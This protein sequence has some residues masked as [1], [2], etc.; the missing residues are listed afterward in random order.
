[1]EVE[2][3]EAIASLSA[4]LGTIPPEFIMPEHEQP[5]NSTCP[6]SVFEIPVVDFGW[7]DREAVA[8]AAAG[9]SRES[10]L[11]QVVN[12]GIPEAVMRELQ[13]VGKEFFE[14]PQEEKEAYAADP[15]SGSFEGYGSQF[16]K[17]RGKEW[18]DFLF[19]TVWPPALVNYAIWPTKPPTYRK[20]N[21]EYTKYMVRLVDELFE[22]LSIGLGLDKHTLKEA[23][24]GED[25]KFLLKINYYPPCP[26]P[27]L[28][29]GV[30]PHTDMSAITVLLPNEV[31]GL[32]V[33][34]DDHWLD[35]ECLPNALIV[36]IGDQIQILS[37][38]QYKS[39]LHRSTL[40]KEKVRIS[41]PVFIE[42]P[43]E[44]AIGP[45]PQLLNNENPAK[46][47]TKK[48][49]DYQYCKIHS[50]PQ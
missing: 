11:F 7:L 39:V 48:Y 33:L 31:S 50:L 41:W 26:R 37:N 28:A 8:R 47:N 44:M 2:T 40:N 43:E 32:Q 24:G 49:K 1:M 22:S 46:Y 27:D 12:H 18:L 45:L 36:H 6:G 16:K 19:H 5:V 20:A 35:A 17:D 38:G 4:A 13:E 34:K 3:I 23:A 30:T 9:A 29:L 21:E 42:P 15:R 25:L 10:G 14:L